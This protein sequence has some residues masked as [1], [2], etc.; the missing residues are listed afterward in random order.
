[1]NNGQV[2]FLR[3]RKKTGV[4]KTTPEEE[5]PTPGSGDCRAMSRE[6]NKRRII[7]LFSKYGI[8]IS[9][10][11]DDLQNLLVHEGFLTILT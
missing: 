5:P 7:I 4:N 6:Q 11:K 10:I 3:Y 2:A 8:K 1:M 9:F